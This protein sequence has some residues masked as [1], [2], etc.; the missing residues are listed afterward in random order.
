MDN[1]VGDVYIS[2]YGDEHLAISRAP[3]ESGV[4]CFIC[5]RNPEDDYQVY[6]GY[7]S[8]ARYNGIDTEIFV[9][10]GGTWMVKSQNLVQQVLGWLDNH[11]EV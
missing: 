1:R 3:L 2:M 9:Q 5:W 7:I 4:E 11:P 8:A 10:S 6:S